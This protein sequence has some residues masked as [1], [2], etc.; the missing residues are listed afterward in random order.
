[1]IRHC[2]APHVINP[3][4]V[5]GSYQLDARI[6]K[7][8]G[9]SGTGA[10]YLSLET[11]NG[12]CGIAIL[13]RETGVQVAALCERGVQESALAVLRLVA[14]VP[15]MRGKTVTRKLSSSLQETI[16][17]IHEFYSSSRSQWTNN[18]YYNY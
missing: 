3:L 7:G 15:G 8:A 10:K 5:Q 2:T 4:F 1:M 13:P 6:I 18:H 17:A 9:R 12:K 16:A 11:E 14:R